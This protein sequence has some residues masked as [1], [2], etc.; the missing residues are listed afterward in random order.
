MNLLE[1]LRGKIKNDDKPRD[2]PI[3]RRADGEILYSDDIVS[4]I[5]AE[6]ERRRGDR[7]GYELQWTLNSNF[8]A[9]NQNC[10]IDIGKNAVVAE[11]PVE[12][13]DR[14][15]RV[16]N[17][18]APLMDTRDAHLGSVMYDMVVS[19]RTREAEDISKADVS[20]RLLDYI[21]T[22]VDF[23]HKFQM[24]RRWMEL[25]GTAF[26]LS[27]WDKDAGEVIGRAETV[28]SGEDGSVT[29]SYSDIRQG[30]L[31]M[32]LLTPYEVFPHSLT[33]E[34]ISDQ[35]DI[36]VEQVLDVGEIYDRYGIQVEGEKIDS[37]SLSPLPEAV[38]GHG[39]A[40]AA[41]GVEKVSREDCAAVIEYFENPSK[42]YPRGRLIIIVKDEIVYYG[43]LPA[44]IMPIQV[45]KAKSQPGLFFGKSVIQDLIPLQRT[46]NAIENKI[47]DYIATV[48]S[49]PFLVPQ[50][51]VDVDE[52]A[53]NG[54]EAGSI[55]EYN[56]ERG[57][58][59]IIDYPEPPSAMIAERSQ[60][61]QDMEYT[62]GVSQLMVYGAAASSSSGKAI[63]SRRE[64][65][66]TR[67]SMTADNLRDGVIGMAKIWLRLNKEYTTGYRVLLAA[68]NDDIS[69][70]Y[71]WCADD[72]NSFDVEFS[73]ENELR[74]S[75]EQQ[76]QDF[77]EA[78][79]LGLF[80]DANG[81]LS[82]DFKRRAWELF[83]L[84][85]LDDV[86]EI[87]DIQ[88]KNARRENTYLES[89]VIPQRYMY[90]DD[91]IH[92]REHIKFALGDKFMMLR[93]KSPEFASKF[94]EHINEHR[95]A[96]SE[97]LQTAQQNAILQQ[98]AAG[99]N[100]NGG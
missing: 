69:S 61:S 37:Y 80:A 18:I 96:I 60:I 5:K 27:W 25:T 46:Y 42:M 82:E 73:A 38:T 35:H 74:H 31:A 89:G 90:D 50:G 43:E 54:I 4:Q 12:R 13:A 95:N 100:K 40:N 24:L 88:R 26:T 59:E 53:Q 76:K 64:I 99:Q 20:T 32:G 47:I 48:A 67:M 92:L 34:D 39:R 66:Q 72:I 21:K 29:A 57:R 49:N 15:R 36:I 81:R 70:V 10:E 30:E 84:G 3:A 2:E 94:D 83:R 93:R 85:S 78:Y 75:R 17:R 91:E 58:P 19:P 16:Y 68:G 98:I 6:L 41:F 8:Y 11:L 52:I 56:P 55:I 71:T 7:S 65:D 22:N 87:D 45:F 44:G 97:K 9:G 14:E 1:F 51:S 86:M 79:Q 23:N 33:V 28:V 62:A 77:L 63:E